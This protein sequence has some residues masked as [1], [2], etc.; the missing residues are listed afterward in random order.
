MEVDKAGFETVEKFRAFDEFSGRLCN[1][2]VDGFELFCKYL[3]KHH[4]KMDL[5]Q[6]DMEEVEK[7]VLED[8]P[9]ETAMEELLEGHPSRVATKGKVLTDVA[10]S[11]LTD[12]SL[13]SLP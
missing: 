7:E 9:F 13:P 3:V 1:Y 5:S 12:P 11:I 8:H 2:Y 10:E 6:L 4:P